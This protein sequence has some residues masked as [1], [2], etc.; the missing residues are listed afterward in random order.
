MPQ[1]PIPCRDREAT[2]ENIADRDRFER[3]Q[4]CSAFWVSEQRSTLGSKPLSAS[5]DGAK[6]TVGDGVRS[7]GQPYRAGQGGG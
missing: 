4:T 7:K 2:A 1:R 6:E 3:E 5:A